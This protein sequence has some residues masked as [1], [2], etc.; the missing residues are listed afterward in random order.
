MRKWLRWGLIGLAGLAGLWVFYVVFTFLFLDLFVDLWWFDS[1]KLRN[2]YLMRLGYRYLT[3]TLVL[4]VFFSIFFFNFWFASRYLGTGSE[5]SSDMSDKTRLH[6]LR[7]LSGLFRSG[8][9]KVYTPLSFLLALP[10]ALPFY[11]KWQ[12]G[13]MFLL[14]PLSGVRD[15]D[16]G[17]DISFYLFGYPFYRL[18]EK[19]LLTVFS[20][21]ILFLL[22][23]YWIENRMLGK[24]EQRLPRAARLH[25]V[26]IATIVA[27]LISWRISLGLVDLL[28]ID[29]HEPLFSG[30]G[31]VEMRLTLP[32]IILNVIT[33]LVTSLSF[34]LFA[35]NR[36]GLKVGLVS[37]ALL[38]VVAGIRHTTA[39]Q[40]LMD[41]Y[42]GKPNEVA[43]ETSSIAGSIQATLLAYKLDQVKTQE[44]SLRESIELARNQN[45][46]EALPNTPVWDRELLDDVYRQLQ[47]FRS[48]YS[49][50]NVDVDRYEV[51]DEYQQVNLSAREMS[52]KD[53]P[54]SDQ[55][56]VNRHMQYTHG[57]G[58]VM[59]PAAQGGEEPTQ[60]FV[61]DI[62]LRSEYG[63]TVRQP[64]IY[65]GEENYDFI[66]VP[67]KLDEIDHPQ[68][69]GDAKIH[70]DGHGGIPIDSLLR[71]MFFAIYFKD[72]N[73]V[74]TTNTNSDTRL[75]FR[76]NMVEAIRLITPY[77]ELDS[78]PYVVA[79]E[80]GLF[81][82]Q[83]AYTTSPHYP[84]AH[85][86]NY[87]DK[88]NILS[89]KRFNYIR[90]SIK[91]VMDAYHGDIT[92]Y[93]ADPTDPIAHAYTR[94]YPGFLKPM[95][96][97]PEA[98]RKH[99]RYPRDMFAVQMAI[100]AKYHQTD[101]AQFYQDEDTW[102]FARMA[103]A[104][105]LP[106]YLTMHPSG[107]AE[108]GFSLVSPMSPVGRENLRAL[109]SVACD[110]DQ[111]GEIVVFSFPR[112][113]Q[114]YG[115]SQ[116][117]ALINSD[118]E[119]A[120]QLTLWNQIGSK[121]RFG[122]MV[123]LP[124][125]DQILYVQP[126]YLIADQETRIP[127]LKRIIVSQGE[128]VAMERTIEGSIQ[129]LES[130]LMERKSIRENRYRK[131]G[132]AGQPEAPPAN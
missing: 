102:E 93:L 64:R 71:K 63:I 99:L 29:V 43:K 95:D 107:Q 87:G 69:S 41:R 81:F 104:T 72:K 11:E 114:V 52:L 23:L 78:D 15:V 132:E 2:Y 70:Y 65:Y 113:R 5:I 9:M 68:Q 46:I 17:L 88:Y 56:W 77:L 34:I 101:T 14:G 37:L 12:D 7:R 115:P 106:Y 42:V 112:G 45:I 67:N 117:E 18:L 91:I 51:G 131:P 6:R 60:W 97:M 110:G 20:L 86:Y 125:G 16:F 19:E 44:L 94:I 33:F 79:T 84:N 85:I 90:N 109:V 124:A 54:A 22:M 98:I 76:R 47:G 59:T 36:K 92:Y 49:F 105:I 82:V 30:P 80:E 26:V 73:I 121:V 130:R 10:I 32:L 74:F 57:Y 122:R 27:L 4:V 118:G 129:K 55:N 111:R 35:Y 100:Y 89:G 116:I 75:L 38:L 53:L 61:Q 48:Y 103:S 3:F 127:E 58:V 13:L 21:L 25:M 39:I 83:D 96:Q 24:A 123:V 128:L 31:Y 28:N 62:P 120:Q 8:S 40:D 1:L 108:A 50:R 66:L 126:I 119:I